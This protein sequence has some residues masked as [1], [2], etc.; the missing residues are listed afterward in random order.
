MVTYVSLGTFFL[1]DRAAYEFLAKK[2][3]EIENAVA[4]SQLENPD[5]SVVNA[6]D[7]DD[8]TEEGDETPGPAV[9][10]YP[11]QAVKKEIKNAVDAFKGR[12][13]DVRDALVQARSRL[14]N[15]SEDK[16]KT[17]LG[18]SQAADVKAAALDILQWADDAR[19]LMPNGAN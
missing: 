13:L 18:G 14:E 15:V 3:A 5:L 11:K 12:D 7:D 16:L 6:E 9:R 2:V 1:R 10:N 8:E 17:A 4:G 19:K